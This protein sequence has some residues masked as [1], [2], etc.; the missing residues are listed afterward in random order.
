MMDTAS[1]HFPANAR[2]ALSDE[3]LQ[4]AL[5]KVPSGFIDRRARA[6]EAF[7]GF[8]DV[9]DAA[10]EMKDHTLANLDLYLEEFEARATE[11]GS[12][13]HWAST[14]EDAR[15]I[16]LR[17]CRDAGARTVTKGKSMVG[18]ELDLN[19]AL[20]AAGITPV[21]TDLG[22]YI[23]QLRK[24]AP[25]HIIAPAIHVSRSQVEVAF[26]EH[27]AGR[28]PERALP[29]SAA[30]QREA[31]LE[32][33]PRYFEAEVGIT[34]ANFLVAET[35]ETGL[36]TN[37]GN[38]DLTQSL[39]RVHV[40]LAGIEKVVPTREA[41]TAQLRILARS[42]TGQEM[43]VYTSFIRGCR[44]DGDPDG[45][46]EMH[47]V[48]VD[49]G[50]SELLSGGFR[51]A[52]RCIRCGACLN[53]C[54]IYQ[55]IGGHAL[56][57]R[58]SGAHR[59]GGEPGAP[60]ARSHGAPPERLD[61]LRTLRGGLPNAD[62]PAGDD[63][64]LAGACV[65]G[66]DH[67]CPAAPR[68]RRLGV[69]RAPAEALRSRRPAGDRRAAPRG[70]TSGSAAPHALRGGLDGAPRLPGAGGRSVPVHGV[71][72]LQ[73]SGRRERVLSALRAARHA[74]GEGDDAVARAEVRRRIALRSAVGPRPSMPGEGRG[75]T[76]R[77]EGGGGAVHRGTDRLACAPAGCG[78]GRAAGA[79]PAG[80]PP[81]G[82]GIGVFRTRMGRSGDLGRAR[83]A[84]GAGHPVPGA[85]R[86]RRDR[87]ARIPLRTGEPGYAHLP[88]RPPLRRAP[89][90]GRPG[91]LRGRLGA[92]SRR[93]AG[94]E[95]GEPGH[96][97]L[98]LRGH[99]A[100]SRDGG[101]RPGVGAHLP[102]RFAGLIKVGWCAVEAEAVAPHRGD[103][104]AVPAPRNSCY[105][106]HA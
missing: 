89:R 70:R 84:R 72:E 74:A 7:P 104:A 41:A 31:R 24:E 54:P 103:G 48:L 65:V 92:H 11:A 5:Q 96:R 75:R 12:Q 100:A 56:R 10:R 46:E 98:S 53:H 73:V 67:P 50:R 78:G 57:N 22:E 37:E 76:V 14:K 43:S 93:G 35:G 28:D 88:G 83:Q 49:N 58:V 61:L 34:G 90:G 3:A 102:D 64:H 47:V 32:L 38:G 82:R 15:A 26:R 45:P 86:D 42:A 94:S 97:T 6:R 87:N 8:D 55:S 36:V 17:I 63:A 66:T 29:D 39:A 77:G 18:E 40:V 85:V 101:A 25:S 4:G 62:P 99:R 27:H 71:L 30:L 9:R 1:V 105:A 19:A 16:V 59:R 51:E 91:E 20:E 95:D 106:A 60:R 23:I 81:N 80:R 44:R 2:A 33:R 79:Q 52:L 13:V 21:E 69:V 68:L